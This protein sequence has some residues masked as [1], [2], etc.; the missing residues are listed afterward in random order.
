MLI[1]IHIKGS[2]PTIRVTQRID[3]LQETEIEDLAIWLRSVA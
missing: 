3:A 1:G 2:Q